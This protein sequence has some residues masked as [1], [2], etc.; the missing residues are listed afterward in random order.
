MNIDSNGGTTTPTKQRQDELIA[1]MLK[2]KPISV[3]NGCSVYPREWFISMNPMNGTGSRSYH[4]PNFWEAL[5][6]AMREFPNRQ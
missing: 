4:H 2:Q 1:W 3:E 5:E 6:I